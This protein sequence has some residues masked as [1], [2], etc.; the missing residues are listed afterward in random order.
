MTTLLRSSALTLALAGAAFTSTALAQ[1][2][3]PPQHPADKALAEGRAHYDLR[4]WDHAI[5]KFKEAYRIR[6]DAASLFN[7]AQSYR[8][9]GDCAEALGF[10]KT[11]KR[12]YPSEKAI[13]K[14][15]KFIVE[16]DACAKKAATQPNP[17][18]EPKPTDPKPTDPKPADPVKPPDPKPEL[19]LRTD[20][21]PPRPEQPSSSPGRTLRISGLVVG[22]IGGA[23]LIGSLVSA[24][25]ARSTANEI[26]GLDVWNPALDEK[27]ERAE[28][29]AKILLGVG[30][31]ALV[32]GTVMYFVGRSQGERSTQVSVVPQGDGGLVVWSGGF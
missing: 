28:R 6:P 22:G 25:Q 26:E 4:E 17:T 13:D 7:I 20:P 5:A 29:R 30:S 24:L 1:P 15:D 23:C 19:T 27:G 11:F 9:K 10:Y 2:T 16:M 12:N 8:L 3:P 14:V 18:T 32:A 31:G 21:V